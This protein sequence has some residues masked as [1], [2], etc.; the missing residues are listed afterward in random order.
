MPVHNRSRSFNFNSHAPWGARLTGYMVEKNEFGIST[1]TLRGERDRPV[2]AAVHPH[3]KFQLTRSVGSATKRFCFTTSRRRISTHTLR[4]E[5]DAQNYD[6]TCRYCDFNSHAP[7]GAR[8]PIKKKGCRTSGFQLTRSVWSATHSRKNSFFVMPISTHALRVERD[9]PTPLCVRHHPNFNSRAPCGAR[10][11]QATLRQMFTAFQ[12]T[13]S[14]W[15]AT[16]G[17]IYAGRLSTIS[18]HALRVERDSIYC[19]FCAI[20]HKIT[21]DRADFGMES[22]EKCPKSCANPSQKSGLLHVRAKRATTLL[23]RTRPSRRHARPYS[24]NDFR[25]SKTASY[26]VPHR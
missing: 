16:R 7:W 15:S 17:Y 22:A 8:L 23:N 9:A 3:G 6:G 10:L 1:H 24:S 25:D 4:G 13:R 11:F 21:L 14:V 5:R 26:R 12:L 19:V 18:T 20:R 2:R